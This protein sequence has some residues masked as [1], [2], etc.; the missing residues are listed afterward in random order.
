MSNTDDEREPLFAT[1]TRDE[2]LLWLND[3]VGRTATVYVELEREGYGVFVVSY[4]TGALLA[5][6]SR[7]VED[8]VL[9]MPRDDNV[10]W[11]RIGNCN[12]SIDLTD[13]GDVEFAIATDKRRDQLR[14]AAAHTDFGEPGEELTVQLDENVQLR[15][16]VFAARD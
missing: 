6:W 13:L 10:G 9:M 2:A 11:Y 14:Q 1:I 12:V 15:I 7:D 4:E 5:H 8:A 16:I 3:R